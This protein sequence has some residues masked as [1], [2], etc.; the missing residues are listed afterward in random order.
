MRVGP[1]EILDFLAAGGMG[2]V[3][4]A[5][6][7]RLGRDVAIKVLPASFA[8][9]PDRL[10]R[11]S[12]EAQAA[13]ALNHPNVLIV[14][15]VGQYDGFPYMVSELLEGTTLRSELAR[16][17][18]PPQRALD[19][20]MQ[21]SHG[22]AAAHERG[23]VHR[24]LKPENLFLVRGGQ[25]KILDFG[26]AKATRIEAELETMASTAPGLLLGT[27]GYIAPEQ[28]R[29]ELV[30]QRSDIFS[31]GTVLHE[32]LCGRA[33]FARPSALE[34]LHAIVNEEPPDL[35][36]TSQLPSA[37]ARVI[38][39]CLDK[40]PDQRFQLMRDVAF[41]LEAVSP[42]AEGSVAAGGAGQGATRRWLAF[43]PWAIA[44]IA[45]ATAGAV[46]ISDRSNASRETRTVRFEIAPPLGGVFQPVGS[47]GVST[48]I[49]PD[50]RTL[51]M[52]VSTEGRRQL[53]VRSLDSTVIRAL[54]GTDG[55]TNPFWS[56][57]SRWI[58]FFADAKMKKVEVTGGSPLSICSVRVAGSGAWGADDV[59]VFTG[60]DQ[61]LFR[62][63]AAGN[64]EPVSLVSDRPGAMFWPSFL[65]DGRH[66]VYLHVTLA[67]EA[68]RRA[69]KLNR[70]ELR[71]RT[72]EPEATAV[73]LASSESKAVYA[74]T[75]HLLFVREGTLHAQPFDATNV[76][77]MGA[78]VPVAEG[79]MY[80]QPIG[81]A[82]F[83]VS[84]AGML[85]YRTAASEARL[86]W[87]TR[88]GAEADSIPETGSSGERFRL[89]PD[90]KTLALA[91]YDRRTGTPDL[92][93]IDLARRVSTRFTSEPGM[94]WIPV[95]S[96]DA[97]R[98][99]FSADEDAPPFPHV[100]KIG[101]ETRIERLVEPGNVPQMIW[102]WTRTAAGEFILYGNTFA[103][104]GTD[105]VVL[106]LSGDRKPRPFAPRPF[107]QTDARFSPDG[108][109]VAYVSNDSGRQQIYICAFA[110]PG[111]HQQVSTAGGSN[112]RWTR[113]GK[114]LV[115]RGGD[116]RLMAVSVTD[117]GSA[118]LGI[119][120]TTPLFALG[121][122]DDGY[123][124][125]PE[126]T[127]FLVHRIEGPSSL[128]NVVLNGLPNPRP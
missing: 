48:V 82:D 68:E 34:T 76:R 38:K 33:P 64:Q 67:P 57:D 14:H 75:G 62:V 70:G 96:P 104:T 99:A 106:P 110:D 55:A 27:V 36:V 74:P 107:D 49:A 3:Y 84:N 32:M 114:E 119:G 90:G 97:T 126:G 35:T 66:F 52:V 112:P 95:W 116:G 79:L 6:D 73:T 109:W 54:P 19:C 28:V 63:S 118:K 80:L 77:F 47:Q 31:F 22:L 50:G 7:T 121:A 8:A 39:R 53:F 37:V 21:M 93:L 115:Y 83:S 113:G 102:D 100:K 1:Y 111:D 5:R 44:V 92:W 85:A 26:L 25:L 127:R 78:A 122:R 15:D 56:P 18:L 87:F 11:F 81:A 4:R 89:S 124:V 43:A 58:G 117:T 72:I 30:D 46:L 51:A 94:E 20:A 61:G 42:P 9:D 86:V 71:V 13:G 105:L 123:E 41:A 108:K 88:E 65:P 16:G 24:D 40:D 60:G 45:V 98:I 23:I 128:V 12:Q 17:P 29:G 125:S 10:R 103:D 69:K 2:E 101:A 59:I 91:L 120:Q